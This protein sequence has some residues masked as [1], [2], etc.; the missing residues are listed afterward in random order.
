MLTSCLA[1]LLPLR[2]YVLACNTCL[3]SLH[4]FITVHRQDSTLG[5]WQYTVT[6]GCFAIQPHPQLAVV[7]TR[8][9]PADEA[10][11]MMNY[12]CPCRGVCKCAVEYMTTS[13]GESGSRSTSFG[14][15]GVL[16]AT[17]MD[18]TCMDATCMG[19]AC[20]DAACMGAACMDATCMWAR[21]VASGLMLAIFLCRGQPSGLSAEQRSCSGAPLALGQLSFT[22]P[23]GS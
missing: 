3:P 14:I 22:N 15:S 2:A 23:T 11:A 17:C 18:A 9:P 13:K 12:T 5:F 19:A 6:E 10:P 7:D 1:V 21:S 8:T 20:M 4:L 16:S